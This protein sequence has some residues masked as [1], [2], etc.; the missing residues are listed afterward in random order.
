MTD[1]IELRSLQRPVDFES[2][3][4]RREVATP[5]REGGE[6]FSELV[7]RAVNGVDETMKESEQTTQDF[8]AGKTENVHD[9][10]IS[11]QRAQM[12]FQMMVEVRNKVIDTYHEISRMQI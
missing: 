2:L 8:V 10:M 5:Q 6:S 9:V 11:M 7:S 4:G 3:S 12:S 1:P